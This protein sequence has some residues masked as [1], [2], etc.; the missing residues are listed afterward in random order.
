MVQTTDEHDVATMPETYTEIGD[1]LDA[2]YMASPIGTIVYIHRHLGDAIE[3][4]T[5][6]HENTEE[7]VCGVIKIE[8]TPNMTL[9]KFKRQYYVEIGN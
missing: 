7:C 3:D 6:V 8:I 1:A 2:L 5:D 4:A 9:D